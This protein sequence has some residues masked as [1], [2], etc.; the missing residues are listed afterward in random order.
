MPGADHAEV[1]RRLIEAGQ[2]ESLPCVVV[3]NATTPLQ[4]IRWT[5]VSALANEAKLPA[6]ALLIV[7]HVATHEIQEIAA[8]A[9]P[10]NR[11]EYQVKR[12]IVS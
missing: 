3:S 6:Q 1:S 2:P 8:S 11:K 12:A 10:A 7:G 9:W 5:T 4:Q